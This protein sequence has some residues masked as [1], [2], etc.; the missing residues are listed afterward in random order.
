MRFLPLADLMIQE[1][2]GESLEPARGCPRSAH[3]RTFAG[4]LLQFLRDRPEKF[5]VEERWTYLGLKGFQICYT[6]YSCYANSYGTRCSIWLKQN[7]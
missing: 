5:Q 4:Y 7:A 6:C 3:A 2:D 1:T